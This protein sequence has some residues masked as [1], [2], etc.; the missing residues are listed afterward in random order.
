[1]KGWFHEIFVVPILDIPLRYY[2]NLSS[3][4]SWGDGVL[5]GNGL[6]IYPVYDGIPLFVDVSSI[7]RSKILKRA[8]EYLGLIK[9]NWRGALRQYRMLPLWERLCREISSSDGTILEIGIGPGGGFLPCVIDLNANARVLANDIDYGVVFAW[10]KF[11][12]EE[13][14]AHN[15]SF[16]VFDATR[17]P[18]RSSSF[19]VVASFGAVSNIPFNYLALKELH[20]VLR[21]GGK[22]VLV[23]GII[24]QEDLSKLPE[25]IKTHW[26]SVNPFMIKGYRGFLEQLGFE[27]KLYEMYGEKTLTP[28]DSELARIAANYGATLRFKG[29]YMVAIKK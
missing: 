9:S 2:G 28:E 27:I 18:I 17:I 16:A 1:L 14:I 24:P 23:E 19:D 5:K 12:R 10:S 3:D 6:F 22:I 8:N 4:G 29:V 11:L 25:D 13:G 7:D 26:S 15:V 21:T 20:R